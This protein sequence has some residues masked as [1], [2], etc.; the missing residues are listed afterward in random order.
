M[1]KTE[2][3]TL[4]TISGLISCEP[5]FCRHICNGSY[6]SGDFKKNDTL[7]AATGGTSFKVG[8]VE[9]SIK[10]SRGSSS[11]SIDNRKISSYCDTD[12]AAASGPTFGLSSTSGSGSESSTTSTALLFSIFTMPA[13][14]SLHSATRS[15]NCG[16]SSWGAYRE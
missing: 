7:I 3:T 2:S 8:F 9:R 10:V 16:P 14:I 12:S 6:T 11:T 15:L 1:M 4:C 13:R 5:G